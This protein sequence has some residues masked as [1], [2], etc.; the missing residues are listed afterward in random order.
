MVKSKQYSLFEFLYFWI[1]CLHCWII[2]DLQVQVHSIR[3]FWT[4]FR[5][6]EDLNV[7]HWILKTLNKNHLIILLSNNTRSRRDNCNLKLAVTLFVT[8]FLPLTFL[9]AVLF[10][11]SSY[12]STAIETFTMGYIMQHPASKSVT[13]STSCFLSVDPSIIDFGW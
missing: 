2:I 12:T 13:V 7:N 8:T 1:I 3:I 11:N 6:T 4:L 10:Q 9:L 5:N